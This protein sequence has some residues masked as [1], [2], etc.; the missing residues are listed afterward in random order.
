MNR[1]KSK[2]ERALASA[3][4]ALV[5]ITCLLTAPLCAPLCAAKTC[6]PAGR[7]HCHEMA[8]QDA[9][10][11]VLAP[12]KL[13]GRFE[14]SA[15]LPNA[16]EQLWHAQ[17]LRNAPMLLATGAPQADV[18]CAIPELER[19]SVQSVPLETPTPARESTVLRF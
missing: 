6:A 5:T 4:L 17:R 11:G 10:Q 14:L 1:K 13:C 2:R 16:D 19:R 7:G 12:T 9:G 3:V 8:G 15:V 18:V